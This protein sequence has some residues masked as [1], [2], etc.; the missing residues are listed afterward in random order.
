MIGRTWNDLNIPIRFDGTFS[1]FGRNFQLTTGTFR[2]A[3]RGVYYFSV[4][5][6]AQPRMP[7]RLDL[8]RLSNGV[9]Q[10]VLRLER[11]SRD[12][13]G[14]DTISTDWIYEDD[15]AGSQFFV[16]ARTPVFSSS[17]VE[18]SLTVFSLDLISPL[19]SINKV[20]LVSRP[21]GLVTWSDGVSTVFPQ[22]G[23]YFVTFVGS[24]DTSNQ[25]RVRLTACGRE[26]TIERRHTAYRGRDSFA[27]S[28]IV[29][30]DPVAGNRRT[31][32]VN[33]DQGRLISVP[34]IRPALL[35]FRYTP[36][37]P[38]PQVAW[39]FATIQRQTRA[40]PLRF[41]DRIIPPTRVGFGQ[42][43]IVIQVRGFY[44]M[45]LTVFA[46]PR[47]RLVVNVKVIRNGAMLNNNWGVS[48]ASA[49]HTGRD[50]L[51]RS[52]ILPLEVGDMVQVE[53][54]G[55]PGIFGIGQGCRFLGMLLYGP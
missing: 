54:R 19:T 27:T 33:L 5:V 24:V 34:G 16:R 51:S 4:S 1:D 37:S 55:G 43:S 9:E 35:G 20:S 32:R 46:L 49:V 21:T 44:Y 11:R 47:R 14:V 45:H 12:H 6:G 10:T 3:A 38:S 36:R 42:D 15:T 48:R 8:V 13:N 2:P 29:N 30:C 41:S 22:S 23:F 39:H 52:L 40:G 50:T 26:F 53:L 7:V 31:I 28:V 17:L 25:F 18:T